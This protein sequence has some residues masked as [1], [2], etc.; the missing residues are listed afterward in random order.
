MIIPLVLS[1]L[2]ALSAIQTIRAKQ[3][4]NKRQLMIFK[5]LTMVLIILIPL[6]AS[7]PLSRSYQVL[8]IIALLISLVGDMFLLDHDTKYF[9]HGLASFLMAHMVYITAFTVARYNNI[10]VWY[11]AI[12][13]ILYGGVMLRILWPSLGDMRVPATVYLV[14]ILLMAWQAASWWIEI[15]S[16]HA[17]LALLGAYLFVMSDSALALERFRGNLKHAPLLVLA[18]Y[19]EAQWLI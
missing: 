2:A 10:P 16:M 19:F 6:L 12:P 13:F 17:I 1:V 9:I 11:A 5:P 8:I 3:A 14:T 7:N 4:N 18:T 15:R